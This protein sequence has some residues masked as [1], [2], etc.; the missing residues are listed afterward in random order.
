LS[1]ASV[2]DLD[3]KLARVS[4]RLQAKQDR[5]RA[6]IAARPDLA[7]LSAAIRATWTD[8]DRKRHGP[9]CEALWWFRIGTEEWGQADHTAGVPVSPRCQSAQDVGKQSKWHFVNKGIKR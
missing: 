9:K 3:E 4:G 7:E 2:V 8:E 5:L 6:G 1:I